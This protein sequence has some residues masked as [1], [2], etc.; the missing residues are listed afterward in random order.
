MGKSH[1][2]H[3]RFPILAVPV[4]KSADARA[5]S[6]RDYLA[7]MAEL[8]ASEG[9]DGASSSKG[10]E[11]RYRYRRARPFLVGLPEEEGQ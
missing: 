10:V 5:S 11:K 3:G 7:L 2:S 9:M 1:A 6:E 8:A 4:L